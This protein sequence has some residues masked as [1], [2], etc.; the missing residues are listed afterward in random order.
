MNHHH[1][2]ILHT[3]FA[4]QLITKIS[5]KDLGVVFSTLVDGDHLYSGSVFLVWAPGAAVNQPEPS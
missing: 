4:H 3:L 1:R 2:K 5:L